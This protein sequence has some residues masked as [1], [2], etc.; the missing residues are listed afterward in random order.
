MEFKSNDERGKYLV[1]ACI[2][3]YKTLRD[4]SHQISSLLSNA[5]W[6]AITGYSLSTAAAATF[7]RGHVPN[8]FVVQIITTLFVIQSTAITIVYMSELWRY[9]RIGYYIKKYIEPLLRFDGASPPFWELWVSGQRVNIL[10]YTTIIFLQSPVIAVIMLLLA[11]WSNFFEN[12]K[13]RGIFCRVYGYLTQDQVMMCALFIALFVD[14]IVVYFLLKRLIKAK[15]GNF[16]AQK[17]EFGRA[18]Y[19]KVYFD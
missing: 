3:E 1:D 17:Q 7:S 14:V 15:N 5:I 8:I 9:V 12:I 6:L 10:Y 4:E 18:I 11:G 2:A 19:K 16:E 13:G